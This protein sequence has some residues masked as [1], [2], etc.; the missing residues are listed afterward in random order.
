MY[1][2]IR[3]I[4]LKLEHI[5]LSIFP[6]FENFEIKIQIILLQYEMLECSLYHDEQIRKLIINM[7]KIG[8]QI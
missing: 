8:D 6:G 1:F 7:F 5:R 4:S 2:V 3:L